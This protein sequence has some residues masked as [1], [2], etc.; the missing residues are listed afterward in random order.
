MTPFSLPQRDSLITI[1][2]ILTGPAG[3]VTVNLVLDTGCTQTTIRP[4]YL[5]VVGYDPAKEGRA[6]Q[7][8]TASKIEKAFSLKVRSLTALDETARSL[9]VTAQD[10]PAAFLVDG[11]IGLNFFKQLKKE[12]RID[13]V[14]GELS[15]QESPKK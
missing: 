13:F 4:S 2:A 15:V 1:N 14:N 11:L 5:R 6:L 12:L 9:T 10:L 7:V 8:L 3:S